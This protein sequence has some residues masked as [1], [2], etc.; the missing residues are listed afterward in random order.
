[1]SLLEIFT[2]NKKEETF[3]MFQFQK[4]IKYFNRIASQN[5]DNLF[6]GWY[7]RVK[8]YYVKVLS[9]LFRRAATFGW[10]VTFGGAVTFGILRHL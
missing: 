1:M 9:C 10:A 4:V 5:R 6:L 2:V 8:K 7:Y 3:Y